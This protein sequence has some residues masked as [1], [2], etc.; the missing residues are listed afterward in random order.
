M[1]TYRVI[2]IDPGQWAIERTSDNGSSD[3]LPSVFSGASEAAFAVYEITRA[4]LRQEQAERHRR[5]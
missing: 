4:E 3:L 2:S 1:D 5:T